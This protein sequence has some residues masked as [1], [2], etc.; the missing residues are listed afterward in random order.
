MG[1]SRERIGGELMRLLALPDPGPT[2]AR[3]AELGVLGVILPEADPTPLPALIAAETREGAPG[4]AI[5][6]LAALLP[7]DPALAKQIAS[8]L[9]LSGAQKKRLISAAGRTPTP[10]NPR[11]LAY[12]LGVEEATDRLLLAGETLALLEG[13]APPQ[14]PLKGGEI[15]ARGVSA[16]PQVAHILREVETRWIAEGFPSP[17]RVQALLGEVL[18]T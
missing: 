1:L 9:R 15:V 2:V 10:E 5:R 4:D 12:R 7:A 8:R 3:M 18:L 6:R 13:W 16:G 11:A 14:F 17:A